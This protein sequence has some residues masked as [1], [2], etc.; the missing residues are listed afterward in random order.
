MKKILVTGAN[1]QLG[2][3]I[4]DA[5]PQFP[6][7]DI[8]FVAKEDL[9]IGDEASLK[10]FFQKNTFHYCINTAA[11]TN[12]EKAESDPEKAFQINSE[13]V[14]K[15]AQK[16][17]EYGTVLLH[18]STD[19]VFDGK[20]IT[21]YN[22][23]DETNPINVYGASKRKG[24][25]YIQENCDKY[26]I[27]RSSWLYSQYGHNF[28]KTILRNAKEGKP[29]T[30]TTEQTGTPTN[31]NDL[32][33]TLLVVINSGIEDYGIYHYSNGGETTWFGFAEAILKHSNLDQKTK[34]AK[35]NQYVTFAAR[36]KYSVLDSSKFRNIFKMKP[37]GW[38][39]SLQNQ[40]TKQDH[41]EPHSNKHQPSE[42]I[43]LGY[44]FNKFG[45]FIKKCIKLLFLVIAFFLKYWII[46]VILIVVG[47]ALGY[48]MDMNSKR[49]YSNEAIVIPNFE[50]VDYLYDEVE[51]LN[52][53]LKANDTLYFK[54]ILDTNY[55]RFVSVEIE[56]IVDI[57][58]FV[59][60]SRENIDIFR[61]FTQN[62]DVS[63][64]IE[65]ITTSKY[66]KYHRL[67]FDI[68]GNEYS[69]EIV[70]GLMNS[71]NQNPHYLEYQAIGREN[72]ALQIAENE[73]MIAQVDS[74]I[75]AASSFA[76]GNLSSQ[77]VYIND[78]S[79]LSNLITSKRELLDD[80]LKYKM[81]EKDETEIVKLV[82]ANYNVIGDEGLN[83]SKK[84][85][86]PILLVFLFGLFYFVRYSYKKLK[87]IS[88][89]D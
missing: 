82:S 21:P 73:K 30:I 69:E 62:Q 11:Y 16:C 51:M 79:Q 24:E 35:T 53:K 59:S 37:K 19:Y 72:T 20:K 25:Q 66:Y 80:R 89:R 56:P 48:Y 14:K 83:I 77:S 86:Y 58:N 26:F 12:V 74:I 57:Y 6:G 22:E 31:A 18:V 68:I 81:R 2:R 34:L 27:F 50:S 17:K 46:T 44:L 84:I 54:S 75:N 55:V 63:E 39:E 71:I 65:D 4:K 1:G 42:E 87:E 13:A 52:A 5:A 49:V 32:A 10:I 40:T 23:D 41:M 3:C 28:Y 47:F 43:D 67:K 61:I 76:A 88:E 70:E 7:L 9:D 45:D 78:N 85:K 29:L 15:L 8:L 38:E 64:Y 33:E 36:P 60:E